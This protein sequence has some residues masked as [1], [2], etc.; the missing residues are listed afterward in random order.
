MVL[1]KRIVAE[2]IGSF[3][4]FAVILVQ[5]QPLPIAAALL[6]ACYFAGGHYNP[7][8]SLM[9]L[10]TRDISAYEF[11]ILVLVQLIA[12]MFAVLYAM[13]GM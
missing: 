3:F 8:V 5:G 1:L 2:L 13:Y 6:A 7:A 12:A 9:K 10:I 4:F 11:A